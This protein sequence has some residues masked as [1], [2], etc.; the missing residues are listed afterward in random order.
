MTTDTDGRLEPL[1]FL[2]GL[3]ASGVKPLARLTVVP[4][5]EAPPAVRNPGVWRTHVFAVDGLFNVRAISGSRVMLVEKLDRAA[6]EGLD[7]DARWAR[8]CPRLE[9]LTGRAV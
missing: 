4:D 5:V 1:S 2:Q 6:V 3:V 8:P 9:R 7:L